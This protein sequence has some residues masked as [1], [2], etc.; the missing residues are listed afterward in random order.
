MGGFPVILTNVS[1]HPNP[2]VSLKEDETMQNYTS[3]EVEEFVVSHL[4]YSMGINRMVWHDYKTL[5]VPQ[6]KKFFIE[7]YRTFEFEN[8]GGF[9]IS[10][11]FD[12]KAV[13]ILIRATKEKFQLFGH[14]NGGEVEGGE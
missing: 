9:N 12:K 10:G 14:Y 4:Y 13:V 7:T 8:E 1:S 2:P 3:T 11:N 6:L 5:I